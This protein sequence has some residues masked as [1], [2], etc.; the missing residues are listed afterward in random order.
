MTV[1]FFIFE[2]GFNMHKIRPWER[3]VVDVVNAPEQG[4]GNHHHVCHH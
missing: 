4:G 2:A 3:N 1:L